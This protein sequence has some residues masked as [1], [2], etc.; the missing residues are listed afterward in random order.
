MNRPDKAQLAPIRS[1]AE[2]HEAIQDLRHSL[3]VIDRGIEP[4]LGQHMTQIARI[5]EFGAAHVPGALPLY[6]RE[7]ELRLWE[8]AC[9][10]L[11]ASVE[12]YDVFLQLLT[13]IELAAH[14]TSYDDVLDSDDP[15]PSAPKRHSFDRR[16]RTRPHA[17][18]FEL[19]VPNADTSAELDLLLEDLT[20]LWELTPK[21]AKWSIDCSRLRRVPLALLAHLIDLRLQ[22]G[23]EPRSMSL[24]G[25]ESSA[26]SAELNE[27]LRAHFGQL[28]G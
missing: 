9:C 8:L 5:A 14:E 10:E 21:T 27:I 4:D 28:A 26:R 23:P 12:D 16:L 7:L 1:H 22:D 17:G 25:L 3:R 6:C 24:F 19:H 11:P 15:Q 13:R 18:G 20:V 2:L